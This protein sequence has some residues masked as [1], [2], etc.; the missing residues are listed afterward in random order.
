MTFDWY[1]KFYETGSNKKFDF[2]KFTIS[3]INEY[4]K[5]A[6]IKRIEW[7]QEI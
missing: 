7:I 6:E 1:K 2:Y 3:Q 5:A 4:Y